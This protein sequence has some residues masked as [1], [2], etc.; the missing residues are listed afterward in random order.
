MPCAVRAKNTF[1]VNLNQYLGRTGVI[2]ISGTHRDYWNSGGSNREYQLGYSNS[3][4]EISYT[5]S[6]SRTRNFDDK[7]KPGF[8]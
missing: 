3:Y 4:N 2:Y 6:A 8:T 1:T 5:V 7:M